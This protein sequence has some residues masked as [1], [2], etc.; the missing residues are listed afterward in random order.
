M[1][2]TDLPRFAKLSDWRLQ[3]GMVSLGTGFLAPN[4]RDPVPVERLPTAGASQNQ[5]GFR[6]LTT[7]DKV[8]TLACQ[9]FLT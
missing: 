9:P 2:K 4:R 1:L 8:W 3:N 7:R 6:C 5:T